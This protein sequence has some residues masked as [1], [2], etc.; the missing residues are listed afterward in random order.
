MIDHYY[1][2]DISYPSV[3]HLASSYNLEGIY[4]GTNPHIRSDVYTKAQIEITDGKSDNHVCG[5]WML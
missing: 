2:E 4:G 3:H 5:T 1:T